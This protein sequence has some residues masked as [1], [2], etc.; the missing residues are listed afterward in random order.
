MA[1]LPLIDTKKLPTKEQLEDK[2]AKYLGDCQDEGTFKQLLDTYEIAITKLEASPTNPILEANKEAI[3][4]E[5][6]AH[7]LYKE[8]YELLMLSTHL[9]QAAEDEADRCIINSER[10]SSSLLSNMFSASFET[11]KANQIRNNIILKLRDLFKCANTPEMGRKAV[12]AVKGAGKSIED[13]A[14]GILVLAS[15]PV[16]LIKLGYKSAESIVKWE[17]K[18]GITGKYESAKETIKAIF[19]EAKYDWENIEEYRIR[20]QLVRNYK[21]QM[22]AYNRAVNAQAYHCGQAEEFGYITMEAIQFFFG[23]ALIKAAGGVLKVGKVTEAAATLEKGVK[24]LG[25]G[26][27]L[28]E[29]IVEITN[30]KPTHY[31]TKSENTMKKFVKGI[32]TD[33]GIQE[34]IKYVEHNGVNY[35]VD[36]HHRYFAAQKL[37]INQVPVQQIQFPFAGY[38]NVEDLFLTGKQPVWWQYFKP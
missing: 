26:I 11:L 13:T 23:D 33:G 34:S 14:K 9:R 32:K 36:G 19:K 38:K 30:L 6:Q 29:G 8:G 24:A 35:I 1:S 16:L 2:L 3:E 37:G 10:D 27:K 4:A 15:L 20:Q 25:E 12:A 31:I 28:A 18:L 21:K 7:Q 17:D 5:L 22:I